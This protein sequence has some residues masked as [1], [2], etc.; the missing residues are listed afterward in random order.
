MNRVDEIIGSIFGC[1]PSALK[2]T[3]GPDSMDSW[4]S[5]S[6]IMVLSALEDELG[7]KFSDEQMANIHSVGEIRGAVAALQK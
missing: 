2:D 7:I 3:D 1:D 6:H 5:V 4:D